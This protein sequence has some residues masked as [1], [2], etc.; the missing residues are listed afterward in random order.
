MTKQLT[1]RINGLSLITSTADFRTRL[2]VANGIVMSKVCYLI[3]LWG[4]CEGYLLN[5]LQVQVNKA[6]RLVTRLPQYTSTR[7]LM[8]RC[9]WLTVKQLVKYH[10]ILMVH[11]TI[12]TS[13]PMYIK[14]RLCK[15][16]SYKTRSDSSGCIRL[17]QSYRCKTDLPK[18]SFRSR[19]AH[20]YNSI[21]VDLKRTQTMLS[22]KTK[23]KKWIQL[24]VP[25]D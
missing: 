1:S 2:M 22:F 20:E 12:L 7:R 6:A 19:G 13:K 25:P 23:L 17:D 16:F 3:Q 15:E 14:N 21:P 5:S 10:T 11:K 24:N 8:Q 18:N 4:G 9:G